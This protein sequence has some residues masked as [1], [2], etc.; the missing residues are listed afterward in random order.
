MPDVSGVEQITVDGAI[1]RVTAKT[2][3]GAH[4]EIGRELRR[5]L[6]GT[7]DTAK[8]PPGAPAP[9]RAFVRSHAQL[10]DGVEDEEASPLD[11]LT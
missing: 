10:S 9:H 6:T 5:R 11:Q 4:R 1:V 2:T 3:P 8:S 7:I